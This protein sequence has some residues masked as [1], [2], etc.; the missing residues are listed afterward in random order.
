VKCALSFSD[1][2]STFFLIRIAEKKSEYSLMIT[3]ISVAL[4]ISE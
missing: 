4:Q 1:S 3:V 2:H